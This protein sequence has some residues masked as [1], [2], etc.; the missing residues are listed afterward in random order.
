[1]IKHCTVSVLFGVLCKNEPSRKGGLVGYEGP[2]DGRFFPW[3]TE[4]LVVNN[5]GS[6]SLGFDK[7]DEDEQM[8]IVR[9]RM[10][11]R[12]HLELE[13]KRPTY[14]NGEVERLFGSLGPN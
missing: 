3:C 8:S 6:Y 1:M 4:E 14:V 5:I 7:L 2:A 12:S 9:S 11:Q 10:M 13:M